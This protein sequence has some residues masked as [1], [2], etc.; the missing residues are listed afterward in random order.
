M[1]IEGGI[2]LRHQRWGNSTCN[3]NNQSVPVINLICL[4]W[5]TVAPSLCSLYQSLLPTLTCGMPVD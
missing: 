4:L 5:P 2:L 3:S 1:A